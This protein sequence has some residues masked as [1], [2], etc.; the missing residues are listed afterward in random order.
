MKP[1]MGKAR[2]CRQNTPPQCKQENFCQLSLQIA[3]NERGCSLKRESKDCLTKR[4][5][6]QRPKTQGSS[7]FSAESLQGQNIVRTLHLDFSENP[8]FVYNSF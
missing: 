6:K 1:S 2:K 7:N 3:E 8:N 4:R 5:T